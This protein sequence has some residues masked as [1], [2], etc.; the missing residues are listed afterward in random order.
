LYFLR[1]QGEIQ[2]IRF[3]LMLESVSLIEGI[4]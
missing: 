3:L 1:I 4:A 2:L